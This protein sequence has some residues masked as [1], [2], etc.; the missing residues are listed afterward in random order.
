M[1][2]KDKVVLITGA[3]SGIGEALARELSSAGA[4]VAL[5]ARREDRLAALVA[6]LRTKGGRAIALACDVTRDG[7]L[8]GAVARTLGEFGRLDIAIANA[9][10][11]V[12]A[13]VEALSLED[14]RRQFET[15]VFGVLRTLYA[16]VAELKKTRGQFVIMGS[17]ASYVSLGGA[18]PYAMSK[19]AVRALAESLCAE[20]AP[21][22]VAVTLL[23]PGFIASEIR[24]IDNQGKLREHA[25]DPV[26][27]W[28]VMPASVA[29]RKMTGAIVA[30]RR[31]AIITFH[32]KVF[33]WVQRFFPWAFRLVQ[34]LGLSSRQEPQGPLSPES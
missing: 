28:L 17:V 18:A 1:K 19:F 27:P 9:G 6:E 24:R 13:N 14:F 31:E 29:A 11:G 7:D 20:L 21:A 33:V 12:A 8:E 5:A 34:S 15:N 2:L 32:G 10:F 23:S 22:G 26:L 25:T 30:R 3:S 16:S 4:A